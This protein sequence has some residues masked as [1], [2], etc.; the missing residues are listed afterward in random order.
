MICQGFFRLCRQDL[1]SNPYRRI[2]DPNAIWTIQL[3]HAR[4]YKWD[5][6]HFQ[7]FSL[8]FQTSRIHRTPRTSS[9]FPGFQNS[10]SFKISAQLPSFP[11]IKCAK[12]QVSHNF[13]LR[14]SPSCSCILPIAFHL[15]T[16]SSQKD[17]WGEFIAV[18]SL[19]A[20]PLMLLLSFV[21]SHNC[22]EWIVV[23]P[24]VIF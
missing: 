18:R 14:T 24:S 7:K 19:H 22:L 13:L 11:S 4:N 10:Q 2:K 1:K 20:C 17:P 21:G 8:R 6:D 16:Y 12:F 5:I 23:L 3:D 15:F 9:S